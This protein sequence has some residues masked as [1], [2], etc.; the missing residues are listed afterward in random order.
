MEQILA[1]NSSLVSGLSEA[2][3]A[4]LS[5]VKV[6]RKIRKKTSNNDHLVSIYLPRSGDHLGPSE[7]VG[8]RS[9]LQQRVAAGGQLQ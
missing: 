1:S 3:R 9:H 7:L 6:S 2:S 5:L 8:N 4:R